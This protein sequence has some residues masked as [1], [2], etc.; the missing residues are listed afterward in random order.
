ML[1]Y[2]VARLSLPSLRNKKKTP[3]KVNF[4]HLHN[5]LSFVKAKK[6]SPVLHTTL[7]FYFFSLAPTFPFTNM[8]FIQPGNRTLE[9]QI[10]LGK[11]RQ[12]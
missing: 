4:Q 6:I 7:P 8:D 12:H 10:H 5:N 1:L 2:D 9:Y 3:L 11:D